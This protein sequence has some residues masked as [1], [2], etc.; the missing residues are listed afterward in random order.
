MPHLRLIPFNGLPLLVDNGTRGITSITSHRDL[1][2][3]FLIPFFLFRHQ[4]LVSALC[5]VQRGLWSTLGFEP[6]RYVWGAISWK[7]SCFQ[8]QTDVVLYYTNFNRV[9]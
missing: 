2:S 9:K 4:V 6:H 8:K 3:D 5:G 1:C 7:G